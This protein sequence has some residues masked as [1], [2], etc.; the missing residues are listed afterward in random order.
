MPVVSYNSWLGVAFETTW[1]TAPAS[2]TAYLPYK[3]LKSADE[4][5]QIVDSGKRG[6][7]TKDF[8][9]FQGSIL[10]K[11][12]LDMNVFADSIGYLLKGFFGQ[13]TVT[14]TASPYTHTFKIAN[15]QPPSLT[16]FD[17]DG[18]GERAYSGSAIEEL[19][20]K[21]TVEGDLTASAKMKTKL[22]TVVAAPHT[23]TYTTVPMFVG[24]QAGFTVA[25]APNTR[26]VGGDLALKRSVKMTFGANNSQAPSKSTVGTIEVTGKLDFEIDDYSELNLYL[27]NTQPTVV[28]TF[29]NTTNVLKFTLTKCNF[30]KV[31]GLDRGSE[32]VK[33]SASIRGLYNA[34]DAGPI[35]VQLTNGIAAY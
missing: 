6:N 11:V 26:L 4:V 25:G 14:G 9:S 17:Y 10:G 20:F 18:V 31:D 27:Q 16:M 32:T 35:Q 7:L 13:D 12:D 28:L 29:T 22:S 8:A 24:Y 21:F 1:G 5:K 15:S 33:V 19:Q 34:T 30:E 2:P 23:P 3:T